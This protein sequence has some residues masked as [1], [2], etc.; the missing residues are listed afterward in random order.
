MCFIKIVQNPLKNFKKIE[1]VYIKHVLFVDKKIMIIKYL[2]G[3]K[4]DL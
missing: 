1:E 2:V 4:L 3:D